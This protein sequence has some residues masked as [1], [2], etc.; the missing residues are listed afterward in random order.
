MVIPSEKR[1]APQLKS[2]YIAPQKKEVKKIKKTYDAT[3]LITV[4]V[5]DHYDSNKKIKGIT[6]CY[7]N[8]GSCKTTERNGS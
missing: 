2:D 8:D 5:V 6:V 4:S 1:S 7:T 3:T